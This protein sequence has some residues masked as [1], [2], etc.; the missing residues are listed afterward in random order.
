MI[1][2]KKYNSSGYRNVCCSVESENCK[3]THHEKGR[4]FL[5]V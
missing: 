4:I 3:T 2:C 1:G 5:E